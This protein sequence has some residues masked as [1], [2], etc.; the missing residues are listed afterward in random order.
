[1][2]VDEIAIGAQKIGASH[3]PFIVAEMSGNHEHSLDKALAIVDAAHKAGANAIKLQTYTPDTMTLDIKAPPF[4]IPDGLWK[5][6]TLY[7]LYQEAMTPWDWHKPIFD[8]A[9]ALG[10][11]A[12][13]TPFDATAIDFLETLNVPCYKIASLEIVDHALIAKAAATKKPLI[14]STGASSLEEIEEAVEVARKAGCEKLILLKCTSAYP[15][16][17]ETIHLKTISHMKEAFHTLVG[18]SDHSLGLGVALASISHGATLIEKHLTLSRADGGVDAAFSLEPHEFKT[19]V[20]ECLQAWKAQGSVHYGAL[21]AEKTM[22]ALR[23]SLYIVK[24]IRAGCKLT[25]EH[26]R[27]IRPGAGLAP[28]YLETV[29]GHTVAKDIAKGDPLSWELLA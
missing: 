2:Q 11:I 19:L 24:D 12:F 13:S 1:M 18:L 7:E 25:R 9:K 5:G 28:K 26:I 8:R 27:A 4:I 10:L 17:P 22:L 14:I 16:D 15:A 23:R 21:E 6:R 29:I 20:E 3:P